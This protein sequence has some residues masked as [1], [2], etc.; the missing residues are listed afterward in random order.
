MAQVKRKQIPVFSK[1]KLQHLTGKDMVHYIRKLDEQRHLK[2]GTVY[3]L[4]GQK[5]KI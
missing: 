1:P 3:A 2:P 5:V 4:G